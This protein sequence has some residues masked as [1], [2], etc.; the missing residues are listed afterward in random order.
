MARESQIPKLKDR[1]GTVT[2]IQRENNFLMHQVEAEFI[3]LIYEGS[4]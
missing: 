3:Y 4:T 2:K 1:N